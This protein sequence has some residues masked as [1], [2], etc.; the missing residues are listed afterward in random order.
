M[1]LV[2]KLKRQYDLRQI[3]KYTKRRIVNSQFESHDRD[4]YNAIY[5]DGD[6]LHQDDLNDLRLN[7]EK[8]RSSYSSTTSSTSSYSTYHRRTEGWSLTSMIK[9]A[10]SFSRHSRPHLSIAAQKLKTSETYTLQV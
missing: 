3:D 10:S 2:E 1:G 9:R 5:V 4:Y 7:H 8:K 6:Y